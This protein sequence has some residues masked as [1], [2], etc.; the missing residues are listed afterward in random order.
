MYKEQPC[1]SDAG[2]LQYTWRLYG[3][4]WV[5]YD[6]QV[7]RPWSGPRLEAWLARGRGR[8]DPGQ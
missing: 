5:E 8:G 1:W 6:D 2:Y 4:G 7:C 3:M